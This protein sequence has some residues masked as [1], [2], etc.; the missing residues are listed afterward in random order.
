MIG[1]IAQVIVDN[2]S[3]IVVDE[4][5]K[6]YPF[7][8]DDC[9]G[10]DLGPRVGEKVEF[11]LNGNE[12]YFIEAIKNEK[13]N[14][15]SKIEKKPAIK[16]TIQKKIN[17]PLDKNID[18]CLEN[19]FEEVISA[20]YKYEA[21]FAEDE[22]LNFLM[23]KRFLN[24]AYNNLKDMDSTFMDEYLLELRS[25]LKVLENVYIKFHKRKS[26]PEIAYDSI[27]LEQQSTYQSYKKRIDLNISELHTLQSTIRSLENKIKDIENE[28][29][30][31][32][33]VQVIE[34]RRNELKRCKGFYVDSI[35]QRA[36]LKEENIELKRALNEFEEKFEEKFLAEY[37]EEAKRYDDFLR[38]QLDGYAYEFDK[39]MWESA[40]KSPA[41]RGFF[42]RANIEEEYSSKIFLKYFIKSLDSDKFSKE[43]K[44]LNAL[45]EYLDSRAKMRVLIVSED[46]SEADH[47]KHLVRSFDKD[48]SVEKSSKP[49]ST[50]YRNDLSRLDVIFADYGMKNPPI[51]EFV[52]MIQKRFK[53]S[54][55]KALLCITSNAFTKEALSSLKKKG[56][57]NL[58]ATNLD[59][60]E[61]LLRV[62]D[63][64][65]SVND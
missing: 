41:I 44:R 52:D 13:D 48:Y 49:R 4:S 38:E 24:T 6:Q 11:G 61:L 18:D 27:F 36:N 26:H 31:L 39:I 3:G 62:K 42:K 40:E 9:V 65:D 7:S 10:F 2:N 8:L 58:L 51:M 5:K 46:I 15:P 56:I 30:T 45:L 14:K 37:R 60:S 21:E 16:S 23:M 47:V 28:I 63:I 22:L 55:S 19:Y 20:V 57:S 64:L 34:A 17:I 29:E 25:D 1:V 54:N 59:D 33:M 32:S 12:V 53:Q 43:H 50:Y 35:H